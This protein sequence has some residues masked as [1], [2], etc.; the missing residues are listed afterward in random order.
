MTRDSVTAKFET[1][2][3]WVAWAFWGAWGWLVASIKASP[4]IAALALIL[5]GVLAYFGLVANPFRHDG[6][7]RAELASVKGQMQWLAPK[8]DVATLAARVTELESA[9]K[10]ASPLTT[11]SITKQ[12]SK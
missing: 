5:F 11:G 4:Q 9:A 10:K 3:Q 2:K 8:G 1:A 12:K 6:V 7:S